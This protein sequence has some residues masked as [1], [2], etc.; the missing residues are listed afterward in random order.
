[1][2]F[3]DSGV[4]EPGIIDK[5]LG[6][7]GD[8]VKLLQARGAENVRG[9]FGDVG[10]SASTALGL[11]R[12]EF[13]RLGDSSYYLGNRGEAVLGSIQG[14]L[15]SIEDYDI[16]NGTTVYVDAGDS[17]F[18]GTVVGSSIKQG[19]VRVQV[20]DGKILDI[21]KNRIRTR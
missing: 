9:A 12:P 14:H 6:V 19:M 11:R 18:S 3:A 1:V 2:P 13:E 10:R 5:T 8:I 7:G 21:P 20:G 16:P 4:K 17:S 15:N